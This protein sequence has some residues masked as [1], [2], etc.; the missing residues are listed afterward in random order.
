MDEDV[1][2]LF[3]F[4]APSEGQ[5]STI[6]KWAQKALEL[7]AEIEQ[8][9]AQLKQLNKELAQIEEIDLPRAMLA[10]GST[11]FTM[12]EGNKIS[13]T[14]VIQGGLSKDEKI[15]A[16]IMQWFEENGG[17]ENIKRHFEI[18]YTRG[19]SSY[20][21]AF[22]ELLQE[23]QIHFDEFESI[24]TSTMYAFLREKLREG[25][26]VPPFDKMGLRYFKKAI[27]KQA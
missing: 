11:E 12:T 23:N 22:R 18:D 26:D 5:L 1:R 2:D 17:V 9:E 16:F 27:I 10:A 3:G 13:I 7:Q 8:V 20:A 25:K 19:Q 24:H 6:S 14:D 21:K 15:R 4:V